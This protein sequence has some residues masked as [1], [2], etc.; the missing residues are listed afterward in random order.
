MSVDNST[1]PA[2]E[3]DLTVERS[4]KRPGKVWLF[5]EEIRDVT[6]LNPAEEKQEAWEARRD[7][8]VVGMAVV[9]TMPTSHV[10]VSRLAVVPD[11]REM[12]V[13]TALLNTLQ[14]EYSELACRTRKNNEA[15]Q[16]LIESV[17][18]TR[19]E[20]RFHDLYR[21]ETHPDE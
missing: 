6:N 21:Y 8:D 11:A 2:S 18:F 12:G 9:D 7:G 13:G 17:G 15:A 4:G 16:A 20:S 1:P 3:S 10:F 5:F 14:E 19:V